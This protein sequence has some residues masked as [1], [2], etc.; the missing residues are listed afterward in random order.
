MLQANSEKCSYKID[1]RRLAA[2]MV[3]YNCQPRQ[4]K[5]IKKTDDEDNNK[6]RTE[7]RLLDIG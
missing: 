1:R 7:F 3:F 2:V 5:R 4:P 6:S